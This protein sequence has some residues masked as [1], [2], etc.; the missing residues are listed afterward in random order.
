MRIT[1]SARFG[2]FQR[3]VSDLKDLTITIP[4]P[5]TIL[6]PNARAHWAAKAKAVRYHREAAKIATVA[7][8][9]AVGHRSIDTASWREV[10]LRT[11]WYATSKRR[12]DRD[13]AYASLKAARDGIADAFGVDDEIFIPMPVKFAKDKTL[14]RVEI[15]ISIEE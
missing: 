9:I 1:S 13:N 12:R 6:S 11:T 8:A 14:P 15:L 4:I 7:A 10:V 3:S 2:V 5:P